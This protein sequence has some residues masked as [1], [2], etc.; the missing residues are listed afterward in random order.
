MLQ[1]LPN[2]SP[3]NQGESTSAKFAGEEGGGIIQRQQL[4]EELMKV[5]G[6]LKLSHK[7][8]TFTLNAV[9]KFL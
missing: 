2:N 5:N 8:G 3:E 4:E 9:E 1:E 7:V 6:H